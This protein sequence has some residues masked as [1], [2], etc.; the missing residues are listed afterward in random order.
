MNKIILFLFILLSCNLCYGQIIISVDSIPYN[1]N[2]IENTQFVAHVYNNT[3]STYISW[4]RALPSDDVNK[5]IK[6]HFFVRQ[7]E[8]SLCN[9]IFDVDSYSA[10]SYITES[11]LL[12]KIAPHDTFCYIFYSANKSIFEIKQLIFIM[13]M[14]QLYRTSLVYIPNRAI[15]PYSFFV[16]ND[17]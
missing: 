8:F 3:D 11:N 6:H 13:E 7:K 15:Y 14:E 5:E 12:I 17:H 4:I 16:Y 2:G 1:V 9:L 10:S